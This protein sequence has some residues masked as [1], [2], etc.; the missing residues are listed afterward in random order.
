MD[1][2]ALL[3]WEICLYIHWFIS[4]YLSKIRVLHKDHNQWHLQ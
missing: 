3:K 1:Y 4:G 2:C